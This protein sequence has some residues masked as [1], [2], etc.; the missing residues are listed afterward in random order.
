MSTAI[1]E[2]ETDT[3]LLNLTEDAAF[4]REYEKEMLVF[5]NAL[6]EK[7]YEIVDDKR[8]RRFRKVVETITG[9]C[10]DLTTSK[11]NAEEN[12]LLHMISDDQAVGGW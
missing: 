10:W 7:Q 8:R 12:L 2:V 9:L 3:T 4:A 1:E 6:R 11:K 5:R